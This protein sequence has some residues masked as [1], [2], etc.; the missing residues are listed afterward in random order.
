MR[1]YKLCNYPPHFFFR[2]LIAALRSHQV[3]RDRHQSLCPPC[4]GRQERRKGGKRSGKTDHNARFVWL[5]SLP[6]SASFFTCFLPFS[7]NLFTICLVCLF[8]ILPSLGS[9]ATSSTCPLCT[10]CT[11]LSFGSDLLQPCA[12]AWKMFQVH[13]YER[14][15]ILWPAAEAEG[16]EEFCCASSNFK[17]R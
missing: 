14:S 13:F 9:A 2:S 8:D 10:P 16:E 15:L 7:L 1:L 4:G 12:T 5:L 3:K 6:L 11:P 17:Q